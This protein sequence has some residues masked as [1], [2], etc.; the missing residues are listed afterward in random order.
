MRMKRCLAL[1]LA[2]MLAVSM[3][4]VVCVSADTAAYRF[5]GESTSFVAVDSNGNTVETSNALGTWAWSL[6]LST[7][8]IAGEI[9]NKLAYFRSGG[10][11]GYIEYTVPAT[12]GLEAGDYDLYW[13]FRPNE[14]SY[15]TVAVS[16]NGE[17]A[18]G[19]I[20]QK[21]GV[22]V[23]GSANAANTMKR[24]K[25]GTVI[26]KA[27]GSDTVR[28]T[29]TDLGDAT[30]AFTVDY[31]EFVP[32][33]GETAPEPD[34]DPVEFTGAKATLDG[35]TLC[36]DAIEA[37]D[38]ANS[39]EDF[40]N[41]QKKDG[42]PFARFEGSA[43][44]Q[45][46]A[47][48]I[49]VEE[50]GT[51]ELT[52]DY[53]AHES[54][55]KAYVCL[56]GVKLSETFDSAGNPDV[57][58]SNGVL[59]TYDFVAGANT[60]TFEMFAP[61][62]SGTYKLNI[63]RFLLD[64]PN[65]IY[66]YEGEAYEQIVPA[67]SSDKVTAYPL[68]SVYQE[69]SRFLVTADGVK[70]PVVDY[71][72]LYDYAQFSMTEGEP[73]EI[74]VTYNQAITSC[75]I[76]PRKLAIPAVINGDNVTFSIQESEYL[77][78]QFN[79]TGRRLVITADPAETDVPASSGQGVFNVMD[80]EA[81]ATGAYNSTPNFDKAMADAAAYGAVEGNAPG[82][83][84]VPA[85]VYS[86]DNF[87]LL[88]N[89]TL[90]LEG[91]AVLRATTDYKAFETFAN[92]S[93]PMTFLLYTQDHGEN[94]SVT[95]RGT[96]DGNGYNM[97]ANGFCV[98]LL[99]IRSVNHFLSDGV[100]YRDSSMWSVIPVWSENCTFR[101]FKVLNTTRCGED[102]GIDVVGSQNVT[103]QHALCI[104]LDDTF[105]TKTYVYGEGAS[106]TGYG[107]GPAKEL[108]NVTFE[109]CIGWSI[110]YGFKCGQGFAYDQHDILFQNCVAYDC[111]VGIGIHHKQNGDT[112]DHDIYNVRFE[113]I[114]V[115]N[116]SF[117][118]DD[119]RAWATFF[120]QYG[121][122]HKNGY[123]GDIRDIVVKNVKVWCSNPSYAKL[124]GTTYEGKDYYV[125]N[126]VFDNIEINGKQC[127]TL[128]EMGFTASSITAD[129]VSAIYN[130]Q[131]ITVATAEDHAA[132]EAVEQ[133]IDALGEITKDSADALAVTRAAYDGLS[134]LQKLL[135]SNYAVLTAAEETF[136]QLP[137]DEDPPVVG[138]PGDISGDGN[139]SV[140]DVVLLR[141]A[142][143]AGTDAADCPL[144]DLNEDG[145]LSVTDV[146]LLRKAIL[147]QA[148]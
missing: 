71:C 38:A 19:E 100:T 120:I 10:L 61:G 14:L 21:G 115:E 75:V 128:E 89:T 41:A 118:N 32:T 50:A 64:D 116:I 126:V 29:L 4:S 68:Y 9:S 24:V 140:T 111:S 12:D 37:E 3:F 114:D 58:Y 5:E 66:D 26:L 39:D 54:V 144:G 125:S 135:V 79:G 87:Q 124:Q 86:L 72:D 55:G 16:V 95:G 20:S 48:V 133:Q 113:N 104:N 69:S 63:F 76:S 6:S 107:S 130:S 34:S 137:D 33:S 35:A 105:S 139:L 117:S 122:N 93:K 109:D 47:F 46:A 101:N 132:M 81:D 31:F 80:Y 2:L 129:Q 15:S 91:G 23:N 7:T 110:C 8:G 119:N 147:S 45:K 112:V 40:V 102:D 53:R 123:Y 145:S 74:T 108:S 25:V 67:A 84:Y 121:A 127:A 18:L 28:F 85:G 62:T 96:V 17:E 52:I 97:Y 49:W 59:G 11:G 56:N 141:K 1:V 148:Q 98:D 60:I 73:V 70:V 22:T 143:L 57:R 134:D 131:N 106:L 77:I 36:Y 83:V 99:V 30:P 44:G 42:V 51:Y 13:N 43:A 82:V 88:S 138:L 90:Y 65:A 142:I 92:K 78:L 94:I 136:A 103:V 27:D 146:V